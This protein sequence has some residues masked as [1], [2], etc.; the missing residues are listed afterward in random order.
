M[1]DTDK[2]HHEQNDIAKLHKLEDALGEGG[3]TT[4]DQ[5][6]AIMCEIRDIMRDLAKDPKLN[7]AT[8]TK[9]GLARKGHSE[10]VID[11][12]MKLKK[13]YEEV[14]DGNPVNIA[15]LRAEID[16]VMDEMEQ[17]VRVLKSEREI[18]N[19]EKDIKAKTDDVNIL[20]DLEDT[21]PKDGNTT[22]AQDEQ[23]KKQI[24]AIMRDLADDPKLE[25]LTTTRRSL[26]KAELSERIIDEEM[27]LKKIYLEVCDGKPVDIKKLRAEIED[28]MAEIQADA[29][30][31]AEEKKL[32]ED[33][34]TKYK[35]ADV[36][37]N[38]EKTLGTDGVTTAAQNKEL[39]ED[40]T[41]IMRDI[42]KDP[43]LDPT[44][45]N[46]RMLRNKG[47]S[48]T[49]IDEEMKLKHIYDEVASGKAVDVRHLRA[50]LDDVLDEMD[51]DARAREAEVKAM[52]DPDQ[53]HHEQNDIMKLHKLE[54]ALGKTGMTTEDQDYAVMC[55]IKDIMRDLAQDPKL[56][57][58]TV[59]KKGLERKGYTPRVV[60]EE[61]KLKKIYDEV[62]GGKPV[63]I[64]HLRAEIDEV[65]DEI[66]EDVA[67]K[68]SDR[69]INNL[70]KDILVK[71]DDVNVIKD[72]EDSLPKTG[73][74]TKAQD[75]A[76]K[77]QITIIMRDLANDPKLEPLS[78][79]KRGLRKAGLSGRLIDEE[80]KLKK[81]YLEVCDGKPVD[82]THLRKEL[83]TVMEEI[84]ED[85]ELERKEEELLED[86]KNK[87][88]D[89]VMLKDFENSLPKTGN[90]TLAQNQE[91]KKEITQ[92]MR[93]LAKDPKLDPTKVN[94]RMLRTKGLSPKTIDEEMK[95]KH[96]Y[97]EVCSGKPIDVRHLRAE[98][99]DVMDEMEQDA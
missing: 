56:N 55:E 17:D 47:L 90:T 60:D 62:A 51:R 70:E 84:E 32:L 10:R 87:H 38:F 92:I 3:M 76:V 16:D 43:K 39:M 80:M 54:D 49:T 98:L 31:E 4:E 40:V 29:E 35:D 37:K 20:Q 89:A 1:E 34:K 71:T 57:P 81:I 46:K 52:Q 77:K 13:I 2:M 24:T 9:K 27:K 83:E 28:V 93:D 45:V 63:D 25:A 67:E 74:T 78:T 95:L 36:L 73:Q 96:I 19:L 8:V 86:A 69:A 48:P 44:K 11:E 91:L 15:H 58:S 14:A 72:L 85:A 23:I 21:L 22:K 68:K 53:I 6:Y 26:K 88:K 94:K 7:P 59:T 41:Q 75:E 33:A 79:T 50:E 18:N 12:E 65:M 82:L 64:A 30:L 97:D 66:A 5:D 61:M 42:A 99:D